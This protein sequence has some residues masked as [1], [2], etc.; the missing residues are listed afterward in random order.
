MRLS[1]HRLGYLPAV[2]QGPAHNGANLCVG[3]SER[4]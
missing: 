3:N 2:S 1:G 4:R